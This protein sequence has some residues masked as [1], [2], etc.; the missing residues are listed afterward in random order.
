MPA[1]CIYIKQMYCTASYLKAMLTNYQTALWYAVRAAG[2]QSCLA[3]YVLIY[4]N[5]IVVICCDEMHTGIHFVA[6]SNNDII[7]RN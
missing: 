2:T 7:N 6:T 4:V 3:W 5:I 1:E